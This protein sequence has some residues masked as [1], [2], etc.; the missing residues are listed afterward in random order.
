M[1]WKGPFSTYLPRADACSTLTL[2]GTVS[3]PRLGTTPRLQCRARAVTCSMTNIYRNSSNCPRGCSFRSDQLW[4]ISSPVFRNYSRRTGHWCPTTLTS[5]RTTSMWTQRRV[6]YAASVTVTEA[7]LGPLGTVIWSLETML[8]ARTWK[9]GWRYHPNQKEL[10]NLFW[11]SFRSAMGSVTDE[12][13]SHIKLAGLV[14][15]FLENGFEYVDEVPRFP[16]A[17]EATRCA[18]LRRLHRSSCLKPGLSGG[19]AMD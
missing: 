10:R 9:D 13:M 16:S 11:D 5:W 19:V 12:Q 1:N 4:I 6:E 2:S 3:L 15:F 8:G 18:I 17:R 14:G 7:T